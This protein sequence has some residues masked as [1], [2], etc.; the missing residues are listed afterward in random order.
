MVSHI[1]WPFRT[2]SSPSRTALEEIAETSEP[3][4]GSDIEKAPRMSPAAMRG[5]KWSFCSGVPCCLSMYATMKCV[6]MMPDT[7][8]QPRAI[9]STHRA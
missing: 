2:Y 8:I 1:F 6:L 4:A 3:S 7:D 5:R 9:S